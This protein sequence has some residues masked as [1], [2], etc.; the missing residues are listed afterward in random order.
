[1]AFSDIPL[2]GML[3][4][5]MHWV[6]ARQG[7]LSQ[8]VA[9]ADMPGYAAQDIKEPDFRNVLRNTTSGQLQ[10]A[11]TRSGHLT[12]STTSKAAVG[13][14]SIKDAPDSET[15]ANGNSVV[16]EEQMMKV[17]ENQMD[18]QTVTALY[19]KGLGMLRT[20]ITGSSSA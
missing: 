20:A 8:N 4:E 9:N 5:R 7:V 11:S 3:R 1:M 13:D 19:K 10:M 6:Q 12:G 2:F 15:T 16:L 18:Y 14:F 17:A